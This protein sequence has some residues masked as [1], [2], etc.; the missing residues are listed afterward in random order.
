MPKSWT[1]WVVAIVIVVVLSFLFG[2]TEAALK[3][4]FGFEK[5]LIPLLIGGLTGYILYNLSGNKKAAVADAAT[6]RAALAFTPPAG[7]AALYVYRVGF[8]AMAAGADLTLDGRDVAQIKSPN[9]VRIEIAPGQH[10]LGA[11]LAGGAGAQANAGE[12]GFS[13]A[14]G[15]IICV[16]GSVVMGALKGSVKLEVVPL[17][18]ARGDIAKGKMVLPGG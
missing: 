18:N 17:A 8:V 12:I 16:K 13:A 11:A 1:P 3:I 9:F 5:T 15:D 7:Q 2:L 10:T 4:E 6:R 14:A